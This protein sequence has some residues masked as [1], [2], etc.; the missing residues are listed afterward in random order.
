MV[1]VKFCSIPDVRLFVSL[2]STCSS[3]HS[4]AGRSI[5][6]VLPSP[7]LLSTPIVP[8][9]ASISRRQSV[10]PSPVPSI[11]DLS[12]SSLSK[13]VKSLPSLSASM[14]G[15]VSITLISTR[16]PAPSPF[17]ASPDVFS[18]VR[19]TLVVLQQVKGSGKVGLIGHCHS[20]LEP[21]S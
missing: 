15:P 2:R 12:A 16:F 6:K 18:H 10:R 20:H 4:A 13:G 19:E 8:P 9:I 1:R 11:P 21:C 14:P 3:E 17:P 5:Q 7:G